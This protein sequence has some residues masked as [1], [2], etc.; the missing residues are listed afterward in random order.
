MSQTN[1]TPDLTRF[2][3][4]YSYKG[5]VGRTCALANCARALIASGKKVVLMDL[6]LEAPGLQHFFDTKK[7]RPKGFAEYLDACL[8]TGVPKNLDDYIHPCK[9]KKGDKGEAW[10]M[11]AGRHGE[12]GYL[13]FLQNTTWNDFYTQQQGY[14]ILEN[15]RGHII[16]RF[17][18]DYVFIDARTGLSEIGG[19]A[20]HQLADVVVLL[21][22]LNN[23][24]IDGAKYVFDS[25]QHA[26]IVPKVILVAS[27]IPVMPTNKGTPFFEK[28]RD[29]K[30]K[31]KG[32]ENAEQPLII[33]Y[34][35]LLSFDDRL[36][37]DDGDLFGSAEPYHR[38][39]EKIQTVVKVD[40]DTYLEKMIPFMKNSDWEQVRDIALQ[41]L[42]ENPAHLQLLLNLANAY[43]FLRE[44]KQAIATLDELIGHHIDSP[45]LAVQERVAQSLYNKGVAL[46]QLGQSEAEIAVYDEVIK[47]FTGSKG[48]ILKQAIARA[49]LNKAVTLDE[50]E[51]SEAKIAVYDEVIRRFADS[52]ELSLQQ[53]VANALVNK[54]ATLG[55]LG[56]SE[57]AITVY[58]EVIQRFADSKELIL[59]VRVAQAWNNKGFALLLN[60]KANTDLTQQQQIL[61]TALQCFEQALGF[62]A[63]DAMA[64]GNQAYSLFLLGDTEQSE[65]VLSTALT[66]GGRE[67]YEAE[68]ADTHLNPLPEDQD[69][70]ALLDKVW[71]AQTFKG[72]S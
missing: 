6:D 23:Q 22:N 42:Q 53:Q 41:G 4:F 36:L 66:L 33:P 29:I 58:D 56:Q 20:T 19:I 44:P 7:E 32:A 70:R 3:T 65:A 21:F 31:F 68:L 72:E 10:L 71:Q 62:N 43:Y 52:K 35:P 16:E 61:T 59:Q 47:R 69:F 18:P 48:L 37:V 49:L 27:P 15:L 55:Q 60:A 54:G 64:L 17:K 46:G 45:A 34:H 51:K 63:N 25:I 67:L 28:M 24:N 1:K 2:I 57:G 5:G 14:K 13:K 40:A 12:A 9:G 26:P 39:V 50:L 8:T 38:L 30:S 11:P